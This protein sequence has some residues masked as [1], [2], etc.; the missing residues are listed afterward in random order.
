MASCRL[1]SVSAV[2]CRRSAGRPARDRRRPG[3]SIGYPHG[4]PAPYP[5][6]ATARPEG[7]PSNG[8]LGREG[9]GFRPLRAGCAA[10]GGS[11]ESGADRSNRNS[12]SAE[13]RTSPGSRGGSSPAPAIRSVSRTPPPRR[14][15]IAPASEATSPWLRN[16]ASSARSR[17]S[18][19]RQFWRRARIGRLGPMLAVK[20]VSPDTIDSGACC[21]VAAG[22]KRDEL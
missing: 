20:C 10:S 21:H 9:P 8:G 3:R 19:S 17:A 15:A 16:S 7:C 6:S 2:G 11:R 12:L 4:R 5:S 1:T 22:G 18:S 13:R 14:R